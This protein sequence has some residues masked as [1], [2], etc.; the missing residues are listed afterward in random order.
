MH[1]GPIRDVNLNQPHRMETLAGARM[2][3]ACS[4]ASNRPRTVQQ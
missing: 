1:I 4:M 3:D 2:L